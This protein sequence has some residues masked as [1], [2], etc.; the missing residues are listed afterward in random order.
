[1][2]YKNLARKIE[3]ISDKYPRCRESNKRTINVVLIG[4]RN[5]AGRKKKLRKKY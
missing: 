5:R 3:R 4:T 1:M 2:G